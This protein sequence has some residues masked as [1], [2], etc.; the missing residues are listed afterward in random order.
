[1]MLAIGHVNWKGIKY[2][3]QKSLLITNLISEGIMGMA[4][5]KGMEVKLKEN[6]S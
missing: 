6:L 1:M 4:M 3:L 2:D 5:V